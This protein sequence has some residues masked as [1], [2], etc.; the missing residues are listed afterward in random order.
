MPPSWRLGGRARHEPPS[1]RAWR[2]S[3]HSHDERVAHP[4]DWGRHGQVQL[5]G[6]ADGFSSCWGW[7]R[8]A[9]LHQ[10]GTADGLA[11][12]WSWRWHARERGQVRVVVGVHTTDV[13]GLGVGGCHGACGQARVGLQERDG[14]AACVLPGLSI[15]ALVGALTG[16]VIRV[17]A[18]GLPILP[19]VDAALLCQP[20]GRRVRVG[21]VGSGVRRALA[22]G[23]RR[24][25]LIGP[26]WGRPRWCWGRGALASLVALV[27]LPAGASFAFL[28]G[29]L[30]LGL[31]LVSIGGFDGHPQDG[32]DTHGA[33]SC[34]G[35]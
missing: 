27:A 16:S 19:T 30:R 23:S 32:E 2:G 12:C 24:G 15:T 13:A 10:H 33:G 14:N 28:W 7:R 8:H 20:L 35:V 29:G 9:H 17:E 3:H 31:S 22:R 34:L 21:E 18:G 4:S 6:A 1:C 26:C 5:H 25:L 11:T